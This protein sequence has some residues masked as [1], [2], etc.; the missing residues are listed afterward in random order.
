VVAR[1]LLKAPAARVLDALPAAA[2][3]TSE[4][5]ARGAGVG[6]EEAVSRLYELQALGFVERHGDR[7]QLTQ[8][9]APP[10]RRAGIRRGGP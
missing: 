2:A 5:V 10:V 9:A 8:T 6:R 7:W 4:Q 3:H 1:D